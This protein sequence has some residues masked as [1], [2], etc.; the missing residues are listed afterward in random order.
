MAVMM[1]SF[2][3]HRR[4]TIL[5]LIGG[6]ALTAIQPATTKAAGYG[7]LTGVVSDTKGVPLMGAS[8]ILSGPTAFTSEATSQMVERMI[9]D[10][11]GRFSIAHLVPGWYS[12]E[13]SSPTRL[14]VLRNGVRVD[15]G[16]TVVA[17]FVMTDVLSPIR[18][19]VPT[20]SVSS[21]GDDWKWVLRT[22]ANTRPILRY[23]SGTQTVARNATKRKKDP[24]L[25]SERL[26]GLLPGSTP[27]DPLS[28]DFGLASVFAYL[29][30]LSI[31]SDVLVAGTFS[32]SST[33]PGSVA[34]LLRRNETKGQ[35]QQVGLVL[36][37]FSLLPGAGAA[38]G[39]MP[40]YSGQA[41]AV[42]GTYSETRLLTSNVSVT[43]G[44]DVSYLSAIENLVRVQPH[45]SLEYQESPD[46]VLAV[47]YGLARNDGPST[48]LERIS[49]LSAFPQ[50]TQ[51]A[52]R[53]EMEQLNH[54]EAAV[55]HRLG[56][57]SR[58]QAAVYHDSLRN[59]AVWGLGG[60]SAARA[61]TG[62]ALPNPA[63]NGIVING[64]SYQSSG[65]RAVYARTFGSHVEVL[66]AYATG[67]A[68]SAHQYVNPSFGTYTP[69]LLK[70]ESTSTA[71]S[72]ITADFPLTHTRVAA[73]YEWVPSDRVT[74]VDPAGQANAQVGPYL[75]VQ[76][77]QPIPT[78]N[79]LPVHIDAFAQFQNL[80]NQGYV[81]AGQGGQKPIILSSGYHY[82]RG[83]LSV[84]F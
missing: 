19:Q 27:R 22:S 36:K 15:A 48:M 28:E 11:H 47:Q 78:P 12:L 53:L 64:G 3:T 25:H 34:T 4:L 14:P 21:W 45:V 81:P 46:T 42:V 83:G 8:V 40:G 56:K 57:S 54:T 71:I 10:A 44:M 63:G 74:L 43:A 31:D 69:S 80:L 26:A 41:R 2:P 79:F 70:P 52:G 77:R 59:A 73:S 65:F 84:Q 24:A 35:P 75:G 37:Q 60:Y 38:M 7:T 55:N 66:S 58:L 9:T 72:K 67:A 30:P 29:Q 17:S 18:F 62:Y 61:F 76:V 39:T 6:L 23:R 20:S 33:E 1:N 50:I 5:W 32:P 68:L 49:L 51:R 13:V 16:E 82:V